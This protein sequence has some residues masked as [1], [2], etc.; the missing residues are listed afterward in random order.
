MN[1]Y[2]RS[3]G[4]YDA[5]NQSKD[6]RRA[7]GKLCRVLGRLAP[8]AQHLLDVACGTGRHLEL[9]REQFDVEGMDVSAQMLAIA[10]RR[11]PGVR[12][13]QCSLVDFE[14]RRRFDVVTCLFGSIGYSKTPA[15][16]R[17]AVRC[18]T[19]HL[20]PGG[21]LVIEPWVSPHR[22]VPGRVVFDRVDDSALKVARMYVTKREGNVSVFD[23]HYIVAT[24]TG[25]EHFTECQKLG[26]FT[27]D[28]YRRAFEA[29]GLRVVATT[30]DLFGY[31][32]YVCRKNHGV[33]RRDTVR[34]RSS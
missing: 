12:L 16:L 15:G 4:V 19:R 32:L 9:L 3:A 24:A 8:D 25:V 1:P 11:C 5:L 7:A 13:H 29:A 17:R 14:L 26:L 2:A 30:P 34:R 22:F 6:Y 27:D 23:S 10:R 31:G 20:R 28:E 18:M 33:K 21:V